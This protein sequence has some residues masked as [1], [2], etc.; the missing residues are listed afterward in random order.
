[1]ASGTTLWLESDD[2]K[3]AVEEYVVKY[4]IKEG[5]HV[6]RINGLNQSCNV[7]LQSTMEELAR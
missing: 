3:K 2:I 4:I 7:I 1:M 5:Y 6:A